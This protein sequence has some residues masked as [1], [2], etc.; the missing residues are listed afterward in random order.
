MD[1]DKI[2][3]TIE[4]ILQ[5]QAQFYADLQ[6]TQETQKELQE[7]HK[8]SE[9]RIENLER[10]SVNLIEA[11]RATDGKVNKIGEKVDKLADAQ[12]ETDER[13]NAV[14]LMAEK[15]FSNQNGKNN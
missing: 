8:N 6:K 9:K 11:I 2:D 3:K 10:V 12:I 1:E 15:F 14:I 13:L 4:I 7:I 5:N